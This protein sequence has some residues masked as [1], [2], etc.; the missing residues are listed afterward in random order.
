MGII[1]AFFGS[2]GGGLADQ[3]LEVIEAGDMSDT[4]VFKKGEAV[5]GGRGGGDEVG[6]GFGLCQ[7][8]ASCEKGT[9]GKFASLGKAG[10][11]SYEKRYYTLND[12]A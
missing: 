10:S 3:W 6:H 4:T 2:L 12:V 8:H 11:M 5:R 7:V 1:K 9:S